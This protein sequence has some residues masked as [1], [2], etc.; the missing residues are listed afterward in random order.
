M[1]ANEYHLN[2][3][4]SKLDAD[5][6]KAT[7]IVEKANSLVQEGAEYYPFDVKNMEEA[8]CNLSFADSSMLAAYM[9][10]AG[11]NYDDQSA[12]VHL[13]DFMIRVV[14]E[15]WIEAAMKKAEEEY[16]LNK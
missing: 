1:D 14:R 4:M 13:A 5:E 8:M 2:Q 12:H 6:D 16:G 10:G 3:H 11:E 7:A 9:K 15:Y